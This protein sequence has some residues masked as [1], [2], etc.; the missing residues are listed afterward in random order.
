MVDKII[1]NNNSENLYNS[2]SAF[3]DWDGAFEYDDLQKENYNGEFKCFN[4]SNKSVIEFGFGNGGF[5]IW[6]KEKGARVIGIE[7]QPMLIKKAQEAQI[8]AYLS[9][10]ELPEAICNTIDYIVAFDVLE[11]LT[12][13]ELDAFFLVAKDYCVRMD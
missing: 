6:A 4:L 8:D 11:H 9:L 10:E 3:K 2:Y 12:L 7:I 5:L 13:K 1:K